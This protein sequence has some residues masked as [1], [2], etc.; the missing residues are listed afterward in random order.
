[1]NA[2]PDQPVAVNAPIAFLLRLVRGWWGVR[3]VPNQEG[4][5][6][7]IYLTHCIDERIEV[8]VGKRLGILTVYEPWKPVF[9]PGFAVPGGEQIPRDVPVFGASLDFSIRFV[10]TPGDP[11]L[12]GHKGC[13]RR[14][15]NIRQVLELKKM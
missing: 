10:G 11:G 9:P 7:G 15:V 14:R 2:L 4:E 1:M 13:C 5:F 6:R 12:W 3:I 8:E